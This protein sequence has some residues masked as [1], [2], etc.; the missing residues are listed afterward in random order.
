MPK[1]QLVAR[2]VPFLRR[3]ARALTG[4]QA[5]GDSYVAATLETLVREPGLM[6]MATDLRVALF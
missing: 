4:N 5:S 6:D 1:S 3:Y 2:H